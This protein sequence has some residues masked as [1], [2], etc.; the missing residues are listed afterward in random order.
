M[1]ASRT[2]RRGRSSRTIASRRVDIHVFFYRLVRRSLLKRDDTATV[3]AWAVG[4]RGVAFSLNRTSIHLSAVSRRLSRSVRTPLM[5]LRGVAGTTPPLLTAIPYYTSPPRY[6]HLKRL[7][8]RSKRVLQTRRHTAATP[9]THG[10]ANGRSNQCLPPAN[11]SHLLPDS[12]ASVSCPCLRTRL[13]DNVNF[14]DPL[15]FYV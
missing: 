11:A 13:A 15:S 2:C 14:L 3:P 4:K 6:Q 7:T 5:Q 1:D 8:T 9:R 12:L 10:G